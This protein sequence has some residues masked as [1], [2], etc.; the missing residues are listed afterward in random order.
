MPRVR[1]GQTLRSDVKEK[2]LRAK[3]TYTTRYSSRIH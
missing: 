3:A 2:R 1:N